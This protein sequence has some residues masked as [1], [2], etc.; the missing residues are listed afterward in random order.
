MRNSDASL[1]HLAHPHPIPWSN[2]ADVVCTELGLQLVPYDTWFALL[3]KS[4]EGLTPDAEVEAA[5]SN[6]ALKL[7][8]F[9]TQAELRQDTGEAMCLPKLDLST[10]MAMS[11]SLRTLPPLPTNIVHNWIRHWG[12]SGFLE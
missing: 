12:V 4:G 3:K 9:L 6:P 10:A 1:V 11:Q 7:M 2:I 8:E 5:R